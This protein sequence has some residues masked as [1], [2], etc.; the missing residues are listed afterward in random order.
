MR[1]EWR[2]EKVLSSGVAGLKRQYLLKT[3]HRRM[4]VGRRG[5]F[6]RRTISRRQS[7]GK[8]KMG[9]GKTRDGKKRAKL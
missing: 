1:A 5:G 6:L 3:F 4:R 9:K 2:G 8:L 7:E